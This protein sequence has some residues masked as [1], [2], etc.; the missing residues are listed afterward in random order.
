MPQAMEI[1]G[2]HGTSLD[3]G[4][5]QLVFRVRLAMLSCRLVVRALAQ[6]TVRVT[7]IP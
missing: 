5:Q 4:K 2:T 3:G 1:P 7:G 6:Y